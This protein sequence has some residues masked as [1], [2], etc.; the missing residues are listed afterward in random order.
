MVTRFLF[1]AI[2]AQQVVSPDYRCVSPDPFSVL[3]VRPGASREEI[4][5]AYRKAALRSHP[6]QGGDA[7]LFNQVRS[8]YLLLSDDERRSEFEER[9]RAEEDL[10]EVRITPAM[11]RVGATVRVPLPRWVVCEICDGVGIAEKRR[12]TCPEC[13]GSGHREAEVHTHRFVLPCG[14]CRGTGYLGPHCPECTFGRK[15]VSLRRKVRL[16]AGVRNGQAFKLDGRPA[17]K[18]KI[19]EP[20]Y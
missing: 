12:R 2:R 10:V 11:A 1:G 6:D 7:E 13:D 19:V 5:A 16:P 18:V 4:L 15:L 8:A 20:R 3:G 14:K 9:R 17:F